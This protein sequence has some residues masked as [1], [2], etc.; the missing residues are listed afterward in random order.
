MPEQDL[1]LIYVVRV[2]TYG[3]PQRTQDE[4]GHRLAKA[5]YLA[6]G[7]ADVVHRQTHYTW[8]PQDHGGGGRFV[9]TETYNDVTS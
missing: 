1:D 7:Q 9:D 4:V 5:C 8:S 6:L 3:D 2:K